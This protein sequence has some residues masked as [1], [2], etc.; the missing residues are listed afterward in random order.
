MEAPPE[1]IGKSVTIG[2]IVGVVFMLGGYLLIRGDQTEFGAVVFLLVPMV[3]GIGATLAVKQNGRGKG[4]A[5]TC[6]FTLSMAALVLTGLEGIICVIMASPI[7]ALAMCLGM[8]IG[9]MLRKQFV[10][11]GNDSSK[12]LAIFVL[13]AP[14]LILGADR[15]E[16]P[17]RH[18]QQ[19]E[20]FVSEILVDCPPEQAWRYIAEMDTLD[21]PKPF[22]LDVGLPI[23]QKCVLEGH[24]VG[25][26]RIC[27][28]NQGLIAQELTRWDIPSRMEMRVTEST[29]P[30]RH[31]LS[32]LNAEYKFIPEGSGTRVVRRTTIGTRLYP[33]FY[34]RFFERW[35]VT[36]EHEFVLSNLKRWVESDASAQR[37]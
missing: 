25:S 16:Q 8:A 12:P 20:T 35:G 9:S 15:L 23:P 22:L 37:P 21:G 27:Y 3:S 13:V 7:V 1:R 2:T 36:S 33:R 14:A 17:Y 29:L 4:V 6:T 5:L 32:F 28:F 11:R 18:I 30:G 31:W 19:R 26:R 34:W 10:D 24:S